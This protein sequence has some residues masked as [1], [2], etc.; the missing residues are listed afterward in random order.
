MAKHKKEL[1][2]LHC[3]HCGTANRLRETSASVGTCSKC[4]KVPAEALGL[5]AAVDLWSGDAAKCSVCE[6]RNSVFHTYCFA[7]GKKVGT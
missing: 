1:D 7:C 5:L 3:V 2:V 4:G 6:T